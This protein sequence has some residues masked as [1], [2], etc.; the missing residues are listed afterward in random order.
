V[1]LELSPLEDEE[2]ETFDVWLDDDISPELVAVPSNL[3]L[4]H[5]AFED[6][7]DS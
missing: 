2:D 4:G 1:L 3:L 7:G 6:V 5:T